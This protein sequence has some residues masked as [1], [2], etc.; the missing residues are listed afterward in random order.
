M[1][2]YVQETKEMPWVSVVLMIGVAALAVWIFA[3]IYFG[4]PGPKV[5]V[6]R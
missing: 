1:A 5:E 2:R 4:V 3:A 6:T